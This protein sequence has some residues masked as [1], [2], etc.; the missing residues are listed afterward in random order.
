MKLTLPM[1]CEADDLL[2]CFRVGRIVEGAV[3]E[4]LIANTLSNPYHVF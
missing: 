4:V 1:V 3:L 2:S